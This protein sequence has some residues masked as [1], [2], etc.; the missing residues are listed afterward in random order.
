MNCLHEIPKK[1][2]RSEGYHGTCVRSLNFMDHGGSAASLASLV[3]GRWF[4]ASREFYLAGLG[5]G[6][7]PKM[8]SKWRAVSVLSCGH[9]TDYFTLHLRKVS[10]PRT[11]RFLMWVHMVWIPAFRCE[12]PVLIW[13]LQ[14]LILTF[15]LAVFCVRS[16]CNFIF[17]TKL[18]QAGFVIKNRVRASSDIFRSR[19]TVE[20][21]VQY[22]KY[23]KSKGEVAL[24]F[25]IVSIDLITL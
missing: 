25:F 7:K 16:Q 20:E 12:Y 3:V 5:R 2:R 4:L 19:S 1:H 17:K 23:W 9:C 14:E 8:A 21:C 22:V 13:R 15:R 11:K 6:E 10:G 18:V 24:Y